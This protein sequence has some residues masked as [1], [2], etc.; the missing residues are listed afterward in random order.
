VSLDEQAGFA[1][2][3]RAVEIAD[4]LGHGDGLTVAAHNLA[5]ALIRS[6]RALE[7][8]PYLAIGERAAREHG[9]DHTASGRALELIEDFIRE[10]V[11]PWYANT[12][13]ESSGTGRQTTSARRPGGSS[14][15][16]SAATTTSMP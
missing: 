8:E 11:L 3:R 4:R 7:A 5:V 9:L 15:R 2:L 6:G 1:D 13:T 14:R 10:E 16:R 12:H